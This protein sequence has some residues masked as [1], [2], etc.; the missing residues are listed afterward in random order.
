MTSRIQFVRRKRDDAWNLGIAHREYLISQYMEKHELRERPFLKDIVDDLIEEIQGAR[1]REEVLLLDT[2]GQTELVNGRIEVSINSRIAKMP[3]V[4]NAIGVAHVTKWH[5]SFHVDQDMGSE[6]GA[7]QSQ[8]LAFSVIDSQAPRLIICRNIGSTDSNIA[9]R[10]FIAENAAVA[11]AISDA[12]LNRCDAFQ[13]FQLLIK[14]G[15]VYGGMAWRLLYQ[16]EQDIQVNISSLV[17]Y[18]EH[19]GLFRI[20]KLRGENL[21]IVDP[22]MGGG[23][24]WE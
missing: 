16:T 3:G 18:F 22:Q 12:D 2:F 1:L 20:E 8:Q 7:P 15:G 24:G 23:F 19:R 5:E 14:P 13:E 17:K 11:A 4:K 6:R 21:I 9:G 10:E